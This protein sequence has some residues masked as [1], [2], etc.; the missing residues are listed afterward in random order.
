MADSTVWGM[1]EKWMRRSII[2]ALGT[3]LGDVLA[4][5]STMSQILGL[6]DFPGQES[7]EQESRRVA[8]LR[9]RLDFASLK[10]SVDVEVGSDE[11]DVYCDYDGDEEDD[12]KESGC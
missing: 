9:Y 11:E 3:E 5:D 1:S 8:D 10:E 6:F 12:E 2:Q 4:S 7:A